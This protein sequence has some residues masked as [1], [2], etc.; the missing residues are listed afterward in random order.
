MYKIIDLFIKQRVK[1]ITV[2]KIEKS[3][4][5]IFNPKHFIF[6]LRKV[7]QSRMF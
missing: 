3:K 5:F 6:I 4:S 1:N 2:K 7:S